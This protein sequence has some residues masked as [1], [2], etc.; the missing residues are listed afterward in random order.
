MQNNLELFCIHYRICFVIIIC[1]VSSTNARCN[2]NQII[3]DTSKFSIL[4]LGALD[5]N[6]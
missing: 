5:L 6:H 3:P 2:V 1:I 4:G